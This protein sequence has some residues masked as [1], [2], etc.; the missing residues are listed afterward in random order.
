[1]SQKISILT[2]LENRYRIMLAIFKNLK[3]IL[4]ARPQKV[5]P[6]WQIRQ[7]YSRVMAWFV[8]YRS[9]HFH[10]Q[11]TMSSVYLKTTPKCWHSTMS[12]TALKILYFP[13]SGK[14]IFCQFRAFCFNLKTNFFVYLSKRLIVTKVERA[15]IKMQ[16]TLG[17]KKWA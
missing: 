4:V 11:L 2:L 13:K 14:S 10:F 12:Q 8:K 3:A 15:K 5:Q 1:M 17:T 6:F 9:N 7:I 16:V